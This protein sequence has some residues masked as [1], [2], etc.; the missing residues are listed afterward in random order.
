MAEQSKPNT[1]TAGMVVDLDP[2][3]QPQDSYNYGKNIRVVTNG[4]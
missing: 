3:F 4:D 1:F 2:N